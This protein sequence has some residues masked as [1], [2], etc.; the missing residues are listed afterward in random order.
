[1]LQ[2][3]ITRTTIYDERLP[4]IFV[5]FQ[6][7]NRRNLTT[8]Y[9]VTKI[10]NKLDLFEQN[11]LFFVQETSSLLQILGTECSVVNFCTELNHQVLAGQLFP[12]VK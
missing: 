4:T 9:G 2:L 3:S 7:I 1:M 12:P 10:S 5:F 8:K 11:V 6:N